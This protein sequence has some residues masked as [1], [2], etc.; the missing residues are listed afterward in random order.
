V[1]ESG[2][3]GGGVVVW[4]GRRERSLVGESIGVAAEVLPCKFISR[5]IC[6]NKLKDSRNN[7]NTR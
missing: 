1:V 2:W 6:E 3:G 7:K 4:C 5:Q